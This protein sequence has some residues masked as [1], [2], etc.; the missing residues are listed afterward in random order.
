MMIRRTL[1]TVVLMLLS[2]PACLADDRDKTTMEVPAEVRA[3]FR[4]PDGSCVQ[5]SLGL[6]GIWN[7]V[8][9]AT[10][11]L[12]DTIYGPRVRGGS[13]PSRVED[14]CE[15]RK[16]PAWNVTGD[17]TFAWMEWAAK[18]GRFA[19]I[20]AGTRHFQTEYGRD[21]NAS[22]WY[23][24]NNNSTSRIDE[25]SDQAYKRL[26]LASGRWVVVLKGPSP[27]PVPEYLPW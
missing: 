8:P 11:L 20:G 26:H 23:V 14:Y 2:V 25:Y 19:A 4:N 1:Q 18:T 6:A 17:E 13:G 24:N 10:T 9:A 5:C 3:W 15:R 21:P 27:P 12:W 22:L 7:N 16:I